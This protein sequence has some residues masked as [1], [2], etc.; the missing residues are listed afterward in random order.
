MPRNATYSTSVILKR[1]WAYVRPHWRLLVLGVLMMPV[2]MALELAGPMVL[3]RIVDDYLSLGN[4]DG[5]VL[6]TAVFVLLILGRSLV[7][8]AQTL[9]FVT[10]GQRSARDLRVG[11]YRHFIRQ[12]AAFFD[13]VPTGQVVSRLSSDV[14]DISETVSSGFFLIAIDVIRLLAILAFMFALNAPLALACAASAIVLAIPISFMRKWMR[15]ASRDERQALGRMTE[16]LSEYI[17]GMRVVQ[18]FRRE[19]HANQVFQRHS[20]RLRDAAISAIRSE[21]WLSGLIESSATVGTAIVVFYASGADAAGI[22]VGLVVAF[23]DFI[24]KMQAPILRVTQRL[25]EAQ[26]ALASAERVLESLDDDQ[27]DAPVVPE[28]ADAAPREEAVIRFDN[29]TFG[30]REHEPVLKGVSFDITAGESIAIVGPTGSGKSS[31]I[32]LLTRLYEPTGGSIRCFGRDVRGM[33][34]KELRKRITV[35]SQDS[36]LFSG[37]VEAN[38]SLAAEGVGKDKVDEA[39]RRVGADQALARK[40]CSTDEDV[41]ER[42]ANFSAGEKQMITFARA[43]VRDPEVLVLDEATAHVD[44]EAEKVIERGLE[45]LMAGRTSIIIAHRLATV[46]RVNRIL[47]ISEGRVVESGSRSE[48]LARG[49]LYAQLERSMAE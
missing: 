46:R 30:Y 38:V 24:N 37:T 13:R 35:V 39:L 5:L 22:S 23:I 29:V 17:G 31:V 32:K 1:L 10:L 33:T 43:L 19:P 34:A 44:P 47:V 7:E 21:V 49:G 8:L 3:K 41:A 11:L 25:G 4:T 26:S 6:I 2:L 36:F 18:V 40:E 28:H 15:N 12:R 9:V 14:D 16:T 48:L 20:H 45:E 42:G 27:V